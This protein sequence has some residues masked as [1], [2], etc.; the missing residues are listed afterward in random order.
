MLREEHQFDT[1]EASHDKEY[2][3]HPLG[4]FIL[5]FVEMWE[6][7]CFYGMKAILVLFMIA[8]KSAA[9]PGLGWTEGEALALYG[10]Y[11][12]MVY[13]SSLLGGYIGDKV[14]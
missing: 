4:L 9:N 5:F 6:Q 10:W 13:F 11:N 2:L 7:F 14:G 8:P 3:G 12:M 1:E